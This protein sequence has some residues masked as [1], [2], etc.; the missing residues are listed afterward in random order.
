[1]SKKVVYH[2]SGGE[3]KLV[4]LAGVLVCEPKLLL[5]DEPTN[6]LDVDMQ[7]RLRERLEK[8]DTSMVIVSHND[9]FVRK[10]VHKSYELNN[11]TRA[12]L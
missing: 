7:E 2:L 10:I 4:A 5:L 6:G 9:V 11:A 12:S 8:I 3:K 1:M